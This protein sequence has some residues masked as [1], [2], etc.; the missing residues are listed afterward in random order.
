MAVDVVV[1]NKPGSLY[2]GRFKELTGIFIDSIYPYCIKLK[3]DNPDDF[4]LDALAYSDS[5]I[6]SSPPSQSLTS[7]KT[8]IRNDIKAL[9]KIKHPSVTL[10]YLIN[11]SV[12]QVTDKISQFNSILS[13]NGYR[14]IL[15]NDLMMEDIL[16]RSLKPAPLS[17]DVNLKSLYA[18]LYDSPQ[19]Q[20]SVIEDIFSFVNSELKDGIEV[21]PFEKGY[22]N[23]KLKV[24]KNFSVRFYKEVKGLYNSNWSNKTFVEH[25]IKQN[26][27]R[28]ESQFYTIL[29][30]V[31]NNFKKVK[32]N[33]KGITDFP[34]NNPAY[35]EMLA[36]CILPAE[37]QNEPRYLLAANAIILF[38]FEYCDFG[39]KTVTDPPTLFTK[40]DFED[41]SPD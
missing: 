29:G 17:K 2:E 22:L 31:R 20:Q 26:F 7:L 13:K 30:L 18:A 32:E 35:F 39:R 14:V 41:D 38:L 9:Q 15:Y 27:H 36:Q 40:L 12:F 24:E 11:S 37:K 4:I 3:G 34:V 8:R 16:I 23:L 25:F 10:V 19:V 33:T 21:L 28:Y 5:C 1:V 6:I